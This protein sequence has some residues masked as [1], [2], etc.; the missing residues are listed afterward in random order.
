MNEE[1]NNQQNNELYKK[2]TKLASEQ[3]PNVLFGGRLGQYRYYNMD[4]IIGLAL[5]LAD[6]LCEKRR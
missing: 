1:G 4:K 5:E 3:T 6:E 2:Y